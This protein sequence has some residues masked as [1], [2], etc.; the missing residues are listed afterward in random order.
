[1]KKVAAGWAFFLV[2]FAS[3]CQNNKFIIAIGSCNDQDRPQEMWKEVIAQHPNVWIWMGDNIY[4]DFKKPEA[5]EALY[6]K[7]KSNPDYQK[8]ISTCSVTGTW[9]DHDYGVN[10]G[11]KNYGLKG[12]AQRLAMQFIGFEKNNPV[13]NH[14]GIYNSVEYGLEE[15]KIKV[16]NLDTRS[17]RDT[18]YRQNY[19]D[20]VTNKKLYRMVPNKSGDMLGETQWAWLAQE[21]KNTTAKVVIINS[22]VQVLPAQ[23]RFEKWSN[24]PQARE[25]LLKLI[26]DSQK[27]VIIIS[28]DRH[29]AEYSKLKLANGKNLF[30]FTSSGLTHTWAEPWTEDNDY[31]VGPLVIQRNFGII[32]VDWKNKAPNITMKIMGLRHKVFNEVSFSL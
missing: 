5:R 15:R 32:E 23:H 7:Q 17:F 27:N 29:I 2:S 25:R 1:M 19:F 26:S 16:I 30:E 14:E 13:W 28:G 12:E 4:S 9:D 3:F 22:S 20:S 8:L 31:R 6:E 10:D 21:L 24:L 11:G 18:V